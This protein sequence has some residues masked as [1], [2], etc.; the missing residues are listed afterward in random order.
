MAN[1]Q[2]IGDV[3]GTLAASVVRTFGNVSFGVSL[4][5]LWGTLTLVGVLVQQ[6][7][8]PEAYFSEFPAPLARAILRMNFDDVYHSGWYLGS[9]ALVLASMATATFTKV[10]PRRLPPL[11]PVKIDVMP[12]QARISVRGE[13]ARVRAAVERF[14]VKRGY[15]IRRRDFDGT[16]WSFADRFNWA[17]IGVL[18]NHTAVLV[19]AAG[20][21]LYWVRGFSGETAIL[22]GQ[23]A[24]ISRAHAIVRLDGFSYTVR[25][26]MT[27]GGLIYQPV[28]YVS[29]VSITSESGVRRHRTV[30]VNHPVDLG[31][32]TL[33]YQSS[34][35]FGMR[36]AVAHQGKPVPSLSQSTLT[37]GQTLALPDSP[38]T[39]TYQQFVPT[40]DART[41]APSPD[42]RINDPGVVL[43]VAENGNALGETLL[44]LGAPLDL[45]GGWR[46]VPQRWI[47]YSGFQYRNDPGVPLVAAG[48]A[49]LLAG[50]VISFYFL[51]ARIHVCVEPAAGGTSVVGLAAT[52]VK[53]YDVFETEFREL[54][55]QLEATVG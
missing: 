1:S 8:S 27:K 22:T 23:A 43:G 29:R 41:H 42:P 13:Q 20:A 49:L 47:S 46:I 18:V 48:A 12:L 5:A 38:L 35:G 51:P 4:L 33:L 52:T 7:Q 9:V 26:T 11:R 32:G 40:V 6:N 14:F 50:L 2:P 17:R 30:R 44:P 36:F 39:V 24:E 54:V 45:G 16:E 55:T 34:Y 15:R 37:E 10:I 25:P 53:G 19:I 21:V 28:D 31:D 3:S